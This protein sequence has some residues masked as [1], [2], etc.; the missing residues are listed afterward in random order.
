[1]ATTKIVTANVA[2][3]ASNVRLGPGG[4]NVNA[5]D[6]LDLI[7]DI[8]PHETAVVS[9]L[10]KVKATS[11]RH[12]WIT[13]ALPAAES[14]ANVAE[15]ADWAMT[16]GSSTDSAR[17]RQKNFLQHFRRPIKVTNL[18]R[19]MNPFGVSDEYSYQVGRAAKALA[20]DLELRILKDT[21][22]SNTAS[23]Q[24]TETDPTRMKTLIELIAEENTGALTGTPS[25]ENIRTANELR[26]IDLASSIWDA[27][28]SDFTACS[29]ITEQKITFMMETILGTGTSGGGVPDTMIVSPAVFGHIGAFGVAA[30]AAS[31]QPALA[32]LTFNNDPALKRIIRAVRFYESQF[33][34]L[35]VVMSR[36]CPQDVNLPSVTSF[37]RT[38][39]G[40]VYFVERN[41]FRIA[42]ARPFQHVP[43]PP[44]GDS[45]RGMVLGDATIEL[46]DA[47]SA[48][49][50]AGVNNVAS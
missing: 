19:I 39:A 25:I 6:V 34:V 7:V 18:Q 37:D 35:Q 3:D 1:M 46:L 50:L 33:G 23:I 17:V 16:T 49:A 2:A 12:E 41:R 27:D 8:S 5:E 9:L 29:P 13:D 45:T 24:G 28:A 26:A 10:P 32:A 14:F 30:S 48:G 38:T 36:F 11:S 43:L 4:N 42:F 44:N 20:C 22:V 15:G 40:M 21:I 47:R 31:G